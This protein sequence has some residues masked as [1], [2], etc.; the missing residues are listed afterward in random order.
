MSNIIMSVNTNV[1]VAGNGNGIGVQTA[2]SQ[3]VNQLLTTY[4]S[5]GDVAT[6]VTYGNA[7]TPIGITIDSSKSGIVGTITR[8]QISCKY[9][10][11]Y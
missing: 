5:G 10:I 3:G 7:I 9:C 1:S 11:K 8:K 2:N 4:I 6:G